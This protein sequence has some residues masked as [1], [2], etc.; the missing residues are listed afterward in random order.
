MERD[1]GVGGNPS[2]AWIN[3]SIDANLFA[4]ELGHNLGLYHSHGLYCGST[5]IGANCKMVEYGNVTDTMG[6]LLVDCPGFQ[7]ER[8]GWLN[9]GASPPVTTVGVSGTYAID[10]YETTRTNAKAL[11]ILKSTDPTTGLRT[12]YYVE[13]RQP[14]GWDQPLLNYAAGSNNFT[15]GVLVTIGTESTPNSCDLLDMTP[16]SWGDAAL[17]AGQT[18]TDPDAGVTITT[19][20]ASGTGASV[21]VTVTSQPCAHA[22]P[23]LAVSPSTNGWVRGGH[24]TS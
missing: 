19:E 6:E 12:W 22:N 18:F 5:V 17:A 14:L 20:S 8:L 23:S 21:Q 24:A 16:N 4:H 13:Y 2:Q 11:K 10:P 7:K 15:N 3:G 9:Y 1:G